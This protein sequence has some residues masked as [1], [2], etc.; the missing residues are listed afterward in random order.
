MEDLIQRCFLHY[1]VQ[2]DLGKLLKFG[3]F[4]QSAARGFAQICV[5]FGSFAQ[6]QTCRF[7]GS[8]A[9]FKT[10]WKNILINIINWIYI[11]LTSSNEWLCNVVSYH[12]K[13]FAKLYLLILE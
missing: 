9:H 10:D 8:L 2:L 12:L 3:S 11:K 7:G 4:A 5:A 13:T 1:S 6:V